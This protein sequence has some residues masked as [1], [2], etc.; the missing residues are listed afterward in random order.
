M[1][2]Q[3]RIF[4]HT[5]ELFWGWRGSDTAQGYKQLLYGVSFTDESFI[6]VVRCLEID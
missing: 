5:F 4:G 1:L 3:P 2:W 6:G